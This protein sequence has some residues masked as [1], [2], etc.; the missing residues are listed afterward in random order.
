MNTFVRIAAIAGGLFLAASSHAQDKQ[1]AQPAKATATRPMMTAQRSADGYRPIDINMLASN[2]KLSNE[3]IGKLKDLDAKYTKMH[4]AMDQKL[5][6]RQ[7]A[8]EVKDM[9]SKREVEMK[10]VFTPDQLKAYGSMR[11]P[12]GAMNA[13][14]P[15]KPATEP[16][17]K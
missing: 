4:M 12:T 5:D 15:V 2:L 9:M 17:R 14:T 16:A 8:Q 11:Q 6:A 10:E 1:P 13:T 7:Q 3:Q